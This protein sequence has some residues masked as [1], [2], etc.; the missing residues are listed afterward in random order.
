LNDSENDVI[1]STDIK[2]GFKE[3]FSGY[4]LPHDIT[5]GGL[6][7]ILDYYKNFS[8]ELGFHVNISD[9]ILRTA[10]NR[11]N[12]GGNKEEVKQ[13]WE[14][15][16]KLYPRSLDGLFQVAE[17]NVSI[18]R[19]NEARDCY[20]KFLEIRPQ[21]VFIQNKLKSIEK[22]I[23]ESAVHEIEQAILC[24]GLTKVQEIYQQLKNDSQNPKYFVENEFIQAGYRFLKADKTI[25]AIEIF[26]MSVD[27]YPESFNTWDS[28]GEA[29]MRKGD[30]ALA[31]INYEKSLELNPEN[32]NAKKVL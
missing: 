7:D 14:Y 19:F 3:L 4:E 32:E 10:A 25:E 6:D 30:K 27:F 1:P 2:Y 5:I 20:A 24:E 8:K 9:R 16:L 12:N 23:A 15:V 17:L 22:F 13:I 26:K 28:L 31:I 29:Y 18:G 11:I 21:E